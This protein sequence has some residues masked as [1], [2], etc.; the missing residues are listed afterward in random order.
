[1]FINLNEDFSAEYFHIWSAICF[2]QS[3]AAKIAKNLISNVIS[4]L[5]KPL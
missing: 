2:G 5:Y 1:M 3:F 4:P